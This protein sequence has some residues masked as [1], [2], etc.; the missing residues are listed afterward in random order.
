MTK[1]TAIVFNS[2]PFLVNFISPPRLFFD[3][4][5]WTCLKKSITSKAFNNNKQ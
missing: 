4:N 1:T 5:K 2:N 3:I